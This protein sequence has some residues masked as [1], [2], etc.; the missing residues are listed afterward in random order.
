MR[1]RL[2]NQLDYKERKWLHCATIKMIIADKSIAEEEVEELKKTYA[3]MAGK[4]DANPREVFSSPDV[5]MPLKCPGNISYEH[6]FIMLSEIVRVA[7]IDSKIALEE[8]ELLEEILSLLNFKNEAIT[9]VLEWA[10][11]LALANQEE[12]VLKAGLKEFYPK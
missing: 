10:K 9:K 6:A 8:E 12:E 5:I 7:A 4:D 2:I 1:K 3:Q 11:R